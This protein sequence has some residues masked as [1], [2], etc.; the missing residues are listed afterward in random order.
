MR[1]R[2]WLLSLLVGLSMTAVAQHGHHGHIK[3][4]LPANFDQD[5]VILDVRTTGE[6]KDEHVLNALN[7]YYR[8]VDESIGKV[9][10]DKIVK[11]LSIVQLECAPDGPRTRCRAWGTPMSSIWAAWWI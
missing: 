6:Y 8:D 9:T 11:F 2:F 5:V 3:D 10:T 7:I 4:P 1:F